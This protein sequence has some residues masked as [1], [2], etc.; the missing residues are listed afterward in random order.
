MRTLQ[1][2]FVC[3]THHLV[4]RGCVCLGE[5]SGQSTIRRAFFVLCAV[6][7]STLLAAD[8]ESCRQLFATGKYGACIAATTQAIT[9]RQY[10]DRWHVLKAQAQLT[11]GRNAF[12]QA[13]VT[14]GLKH[15]ATSVR[16]RHLGYQTLLRAGQVEQARK[17]LGE[18][19]DLATRAPWRYTDTENLITL[20]ESALLVGVDARDVLEGFYDKA[21]SN[22]P[23]RVEPLVAIAELALTKNDREQRATCRG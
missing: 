3:A 23:D 15:N 12:A 4:D 21:R 5:W 20:G 6:F 17:L 13:T 16:L 22:S 11:L 10:G 1:S 7:P 9:V 18:I 2:L 14:D 8:Y 19:D